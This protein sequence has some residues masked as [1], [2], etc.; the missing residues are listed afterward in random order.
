VTAARS[1]GARRRPLQA[2]AAFVETRGAIVGAETLARDALTALY[3][4]DTARRV[5]LSEV[6]ALR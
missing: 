4:A 5:P 1:A 2:L 3:R 6:D